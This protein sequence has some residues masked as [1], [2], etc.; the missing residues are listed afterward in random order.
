MCFVYVALG[1]E[2]ENKQCTDIFLRGRRH[3]VQARVVSAPHAY[4][5]TLHGT[6][7]LYNLQSIYSK[8]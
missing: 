8:L 4:D 6:W 5:Y 1:P 3:V 2:R 7:G